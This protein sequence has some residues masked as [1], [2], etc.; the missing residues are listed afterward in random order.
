MEE[1]A[2]VKKIKLADFGSLTKSVFFTKF[3][4]KIGDKKVSGIEFD[5]FKTYLGHYKAGQEETFNFLS[6][7]MIVKR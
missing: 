7:Y 1:E 4:K 2:I 5:G 6:Y 3:I